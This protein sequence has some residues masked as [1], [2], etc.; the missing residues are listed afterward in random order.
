VLFFADS[1]GEPKIDEF[2]LCIFDEGENLCGLHGSFLQVYCIKRG[3]PIA[4]W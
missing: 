1:V 2:D 3:P 4:A